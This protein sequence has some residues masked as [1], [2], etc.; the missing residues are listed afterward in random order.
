MN[1]PGVACTSAPIADTCA[2]L[3]VIFRA[4][5][6]SVARA[7]YRVIQDAGR[8]EEL[9]VETFIRWSKALPD[10]GRN[11]EG[12]LYRTAMRIALDELRH[13]S[14][15][16]RY[17]KLAQ[18]FLPSPTPEQIHVAEEERSAVRDVLCKLGR[19]QAELLL[20]RVS[21]V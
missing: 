13:R 11:P 9:A 19:A 12:W 10:S 20:L 4:H 2:E 16:H 6:R 15:R 17:E 21:M 3:E 18:L 1:V 7:I 8:A 14:R 5:Y